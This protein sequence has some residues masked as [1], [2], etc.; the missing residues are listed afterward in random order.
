MRKT[1]V[2]LAVTALV[3]APLTAA[4]AAPARYKV[5]VGSSDKTLDLTS[6]DGTNRTTVIKGRVRGGSVKGTK[7]Y[8]YAAN[9]SARNQGFRYIGSDRVSSKGRFAKK[10]KPRDG[11][12]YVVKV[13]KRKGK[14]RAEGT[15]TTR[16]NVF[17]FVSLSN[18]YVPA[19]SPGTSRVDKAGSINGQNWSTAYQVEPG[20]SAV[21]ATQGFRCL[22]INFK[23][24]VADAARG[25][26]GSFR[27]GQGSRTILAGSHGFGQSFIQPS[28]AQ[29]KRM[30]ASQPVTVSVSGNAPFV[31]GLPKA[32]CTYPT[33]TAPK[34]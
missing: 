15:G 25:G 3:V 17:Q 33:R 32:A 28:T 5:S 12:S 7:V 20:G 8:V 14:G 34:A 29:Q 4:E 11:G 1:L 19:A 2:A 24:G 22:R 10:W 23:I 27:V 18:F 31:L 26:S 9:T 13:V 21:F 6:D 30:T 16:V